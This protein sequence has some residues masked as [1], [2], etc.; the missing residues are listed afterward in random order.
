ME[1]RRGSVLVVSKVGE[2]QSRHEEGGGP[3]RGSKE[4]GAAGESEDV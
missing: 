2:R 1:K 3:G 4:Y